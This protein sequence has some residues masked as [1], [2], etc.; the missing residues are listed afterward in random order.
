MVATG[1]WSQGTDVNMKLIMSAVLLLVCL[2]SLANKR[3]M[4][5]IYMLDFVTGYLISLQA[6]QNFSTLIVLKK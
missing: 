2:L 5:S 4:S 3:A 6:G 1:I